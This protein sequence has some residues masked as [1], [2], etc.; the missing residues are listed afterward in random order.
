[1]K[2]NNK[3]AVAAHRLQEIFRKIDAIESGELKIDAAEH[4]DMFAEIT[5]ASSII[6]GYICNHIK[7]YMPE[8]SLKRAS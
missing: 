1:M 3:A 4:A 2:T 7:Y 5:D 8:Y 6:S